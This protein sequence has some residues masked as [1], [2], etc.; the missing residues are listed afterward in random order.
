MTA[1]SASLTNL[2]ALPPQ[3]HDCSYYVSRPIL[4]PLPISLQRHADLCAHDFAHS[5]D[6]WHQPRLADATYAWSCRLCRIN[7]AVP[8]HHTCT[9]CDAP[10]LDWL[11][12]HSHNHV[13]ICERCILWLH[14]ERVSFGQPS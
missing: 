10:V 6:L 14:C 7:P 3:S 2:T 1:F 13:I 5:A 9:S 8:C 4:A 11:V 12:C